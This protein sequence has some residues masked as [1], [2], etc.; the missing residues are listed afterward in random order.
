MKHCV[1]VCQCV[2]VN[3]CDNLPMDESALVEEDEQV[4]NEEGGEIIFPCIVE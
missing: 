3:V 4:D 2:W 1:R